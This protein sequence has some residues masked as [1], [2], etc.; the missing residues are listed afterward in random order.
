MWV[1]SVTGETRP[2]K[3]LGAG[4]HARSAREVDLPGEVAN[5]PVYRLLVDK[6]AGGQ[7]WQDRESP[8]AEDAGELLAAPPARGLDEGSGERVPGVV[9]GRCG[10]GGNGSVVLVVREEDGQ[11]PFRGGHRGRVRPRDGAA[12]ANPPSYPQVVII[13]SRPSG[14]S[15]S[16]AVARRQA[17]ASEV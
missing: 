16:S 17:R 13:Y 14:L 2:Q 3:P 4:L 11:R 15:S 6:A 12:P 8:L 7:A 10:S 5:R 9:V 1:V